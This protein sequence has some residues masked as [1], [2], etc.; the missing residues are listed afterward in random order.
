M[1]RK[2]NLL[3]FNE[4]YEKSFCIQSF[5]CVFLSF[6][7]SIFVYVELYRIGVD[8]SRFRRDF[9]AAP[10]HELEHTFSTFISFTSRATG[11]QVELRQ[12]A[13]SQ[14]NNPRC[15]DKC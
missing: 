9:I 11:T 12:F 8:P 2:A 4:K 15:L 7:S 10:D 1:H 14:S 3:I 13:L 6:S 5:F